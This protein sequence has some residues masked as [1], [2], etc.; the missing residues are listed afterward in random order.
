MIFLVCM[1]VWGGGDSHTVRGKLGDLT[2]V[3]CWE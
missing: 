3:N 1:Y 2:K